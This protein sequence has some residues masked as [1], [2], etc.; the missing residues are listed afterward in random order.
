[1]LIYL[2]SLLFD[3]RRIELKCVIERGQCR[4]KKKKSDQTRFHFSVA[5]SR[6]RDSNYVDVPLALF[7]RKLHDT[8]QT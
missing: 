3:N 2:K 4:S 8:V 5:F 6:A 1:M 7:A